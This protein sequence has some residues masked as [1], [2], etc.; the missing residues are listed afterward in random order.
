MWAERRATRSGTYDAWRERVRARMASRAENPLPGA[1]VTLA[2]GAATPHGNTPHEGIDMAAASGTPV[3]APLEGAV[4]RVE[5]AGKSGTIV[6]LSHGA[7][8]ETRLR[9][10]GE[11]SVRPGQKV[12]PG[13]VIG[14]VGEPE[15]GPHVHFE[16]RDNGDPI[17]PA[18][19]LG[20]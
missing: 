5:A 16:V 17:D 9:G 3:H 19:Y 6:V 4:L 1:R 13:D 2:F 12:A 14:A 18:R 15:G 10:L 8:I 20:Q 7:G 11:A